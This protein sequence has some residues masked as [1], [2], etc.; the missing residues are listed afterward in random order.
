[1]V[2]VHYRLAVWSNITSIISMSD[3]RLIVRVATIL[4]IRFL[5]LRGNLDVLVYSPYEKI[6]SG[7]SMTLQVSQDL[8]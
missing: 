2:P 5:S 8:S 4:L 1:M 3:I 6:N 7:Y